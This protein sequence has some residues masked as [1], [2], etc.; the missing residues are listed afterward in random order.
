MSELV[1]ASIVIAWGKTNDELPAER[2]HDA[3][4]RA[5]S[6]SK[7]IRC[8]FTIIFI[9]G[10]AKKGQRWMGRRLHGLDK[11]LQRCLLLQRIGVFL[12]RCQALLGIL[13]VCLSRE[14]MVRPVQHSA[15]RILNIESSYLEEASN[16]VS[17]L[18][19]VEE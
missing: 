18:F 3:L 6:L 17:Q 8:T 5:T 16:S 13:K 10:E 19:V 11:C 1:S 9:G 4:N 15:V 7:R 14:A 12:H 2:K